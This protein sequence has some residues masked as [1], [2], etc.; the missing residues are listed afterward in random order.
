MS[1]PALI[2]PF[3]AYLETQDRAATTIVNY[4]YNLQAFFAWF[5][6][7][8]G[9][10]PEVAKVT[11]LDIRQ[12]REWLKERCKPNTVNRKLIYLVGFFR[13][14]SDNG[15]TATNPAAAIKLVKMVK[16]A[17]R[18]LGRPQ[19]H[20]LLRATEQAVNQARNKRLTFTEQVATRTMAIV[21]LILSTGIRVSE[22]CDLKNSDVKLGSKSGLVTIR[23]GKGG[24]YREVP[25]NADARR[26]LAHWL[27]VRPSHPGGYFFSTP[28]GRMTRQLV[29]WHL[30]ELG[31]SVDI[32]LSPH[33]L[34]HTFG[35]NLVDSGESLD[36]VA[37]LLGHSDVNTTALYTIPSLGDLQRAVDKISWS[38]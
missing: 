9:Q 24:K 30:S 12:Y 20:A 23:S 35:K 18:W 3:L 26:A 2:G 17:P 22:L 7:T 5:S 37:M 19:Q 33:V 29:E 14:C 16:H 34:R 32:P 28:G 36:R 1:G 13:W 38:D 6:E 4:R 15:H 21:T 11:P 25:L 31:K 27:K 8:S 10:A